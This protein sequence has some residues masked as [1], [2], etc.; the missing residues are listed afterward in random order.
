MVLLGSLADVVALPVL[1]LEMVVVLSDSDLVFLET[2]VL[3]MREF[4]TAL[5]IFLHFYIN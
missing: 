5:L 2:L 1:P 3:E 4:T